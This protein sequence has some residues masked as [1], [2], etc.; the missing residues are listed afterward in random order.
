MQTFNNVEF[1]P[2]FDFNRQVI[3]EKSN[4]LSDLQ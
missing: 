1:K 2:F 4:V 3:I